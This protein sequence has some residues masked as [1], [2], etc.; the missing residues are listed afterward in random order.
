MEWEESAYTLATLAN[1][2]TKGL[3][4]HPR[5]S[6]IFTTWDI[7]SMEQ[8]EETQNTKRKSSFFM[9]LFLFLLL[10]HLAPL[11]RF[12]TKK[13]KKT[14]KRRNWERKDRRRVDMGG[15]DAYKVGTWICACLD[16]VAAVECSSRINPLPLSPCAFVPYFSPTIVCFVVE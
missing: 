2:C 15:N 7:H 4:I 11:T 10:N 13:K 14:N 3:L 8:D 6:L 12:S 1:M 5:R 16:K 9:F